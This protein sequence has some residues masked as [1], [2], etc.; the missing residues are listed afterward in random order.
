MEAWSLTDAVEVIEDSGLVVSHQDEWRGAIEF[1]DVGAIAYLLRAV[2]WIVDNFSVDRYQRQLYRLQRR[3]DVGK[4]LRF[5]RASF[6]VEANA[7]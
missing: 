3:L 5:T 2:P 6:I 1:R 4:P 7:P